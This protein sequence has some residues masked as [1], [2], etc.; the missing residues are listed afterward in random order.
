MDGCGKKVRA[1]N[2]ASTYSVMF[3]C[4]ARLQPTKA[5]ARRFAPTGYCLCMYALPSKNWFFV[6]R[7]AMFPIFKLAKVQC[8]S[9][10]PWP[11]LCRA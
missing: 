9:A 4:R 3:M 7:M 2:F 5:M 11:W 8:V 10:W 6:K 1:V